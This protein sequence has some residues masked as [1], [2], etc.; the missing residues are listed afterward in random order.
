MFLAKSGAGVLAVRQTDRWGPDG[1][2]RREPRS[3]RLAESWPD[4]HASTAPSVRLAARRRRGRSGSAERGAWRQHRM[5]RQRNGVRGRRPNP[6]IFA[7]R[8]VTHL[9]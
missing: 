1:R 4:R 3:Q 8:L 7:N 2:T 9:N 5:L 6:V